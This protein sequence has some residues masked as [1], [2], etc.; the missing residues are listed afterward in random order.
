VTADRRADECEPP[1]WDHPLPVYT[2]DAGERHGYDVVSTGVLPRLTT[3]LG[4]RSADAGTAGEDAAVT[5]QSNSMRMAVEF[6]FTVAF[7]IPL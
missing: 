2:A 5:G 6:C 3:C 1:I 4:P 7:A